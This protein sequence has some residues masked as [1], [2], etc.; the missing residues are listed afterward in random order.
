MTITADATRAEIRQ[1]VLDIAAL[2]PEDSRKAALRFTASVLGLPFARVKRWYYDEVRRVEAHEADQIRAY[3]D[4]A[5][6][7]IQARADYEALR[8]EYLATAHPSLAR[9]APGAL[10]GKEAAPDEVAVAPR[11]RAGGP[12]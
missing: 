9:F 6:K 10:D 7:L 12:I 1:R 5:Q 3:F 4:A 2:A 11:E 8:R